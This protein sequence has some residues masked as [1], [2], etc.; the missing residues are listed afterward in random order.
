MSKWL[1]PGTSLKWKMIRRTK[2]FPHPSELGR[3]NFR[4]WHLFAGHLLFLFHDHFFDHLT[5][6]AAGLCR[7][8]VTVVTLF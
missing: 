4:N 8:Q 1:V 7:S 6:D 5:T 2:K 3:G